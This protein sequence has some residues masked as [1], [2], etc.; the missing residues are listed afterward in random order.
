MEKPDNP[1]DKP[2]VMSSRDVKDR[3]VLDAISHAQS[4]FIRDED[5]KKVFNYLLESILTISESE[6]GF[7]G[8]I[9]YTDENQPYLKTHAITNIAWNDETRK[10]YEENAPGGMEFYNL[11]S[12]F[13]VTIATGGLVISNNPNDD[14]RKGGLPEGHP[15][16]NAYLGIPF[17]VGK[18][19]VGMAGLANRDQGYDQEIV[20]YLQPLINTC[21]QLIDAHRNEQQKQSA[22]AKL[23]DS[24]KRLEL[25]IDGSNA[26]LWDWDITTDDVWYAPR[27]REMLGYKDEKEFPNR[28]FRT[29]LF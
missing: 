23:H 24:E 25:A 6:Y 7:I 19:F 9:L 27:F 15:D 5:T 18:D 14:V 26:G 8:E 3:Q 13:G 28:L 12:L 17:Y 20:D 2:K 4:R 1:K 10:F 16:L 22:F 21:A 29:T 11:K